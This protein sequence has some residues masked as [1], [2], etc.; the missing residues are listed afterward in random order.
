MNNM[1]CTRLGTMLYLD[2]QKWKENMKTSEFQKNLGVTA[3]CMNRLAMAAKGCVQMTSNYT[4]FYGSRF[5]YVKTAEEA[6]AAGFDYCGTAK[7]SYK[8]F[9]LAILEN[10]MKYW[11]GGSYIFIK[12]NTRVPGVIPLLYIGYKYN[13]R[14]VL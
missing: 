8:E 7:T 14:K 4:Y 9:C 11:P 12:S 3:A 5:S 13:S 2:I 1:E 6:I 10:L